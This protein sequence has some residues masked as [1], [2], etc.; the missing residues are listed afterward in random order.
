MSRSKTDPVKLARLS[1]ALEKWCDDNE[2]RYKQCSEYQ[3][4]VYVPEV[5]VIIAVYPG[6]GVIWVPQAHYTDTGA[7]D[8]SSTKYRF[9]D[10]EKMFKLLQKIIF[11]AD[12][13]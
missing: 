1:L 7:I 9:I 6:S 12:A 5:Q 13:V 4:N 3:W 10:E 8:K 2:I 11:A